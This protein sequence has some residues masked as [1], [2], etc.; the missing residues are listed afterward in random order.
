MAPGAPGRLMTTKDCPVSRVAASA[1][2]RATASLPPPTAHGTMI[3]TLRAGDGSARGPGDGAGGHAG[4]GGRGGAMDKRVRRM[5]KQDGSQGRGAVGGM[6][7][8]WLSR[9]I[10]AP[11]AGGKAEE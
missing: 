9:W 4:A 1:K 7:I 6:V 8:L 3:S 10:G 11:G 2:A 5:G